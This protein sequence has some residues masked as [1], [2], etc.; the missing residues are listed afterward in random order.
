MR[1]KLMGNKREK[2]KNKKKK[3]DIESMGT[4]S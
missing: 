2:K 4:G 3:A 1:G